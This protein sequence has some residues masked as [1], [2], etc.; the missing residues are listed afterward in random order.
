MIYFLY[1]K[2]YPFLN[3]RFKFQYA[4]IDA[5]DDGFPFAG[6]DF[7]KKAYAKAI[8]EKYKFYAFEDALLII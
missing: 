3:F 7:I 6:H 2:R 8:N 5:D 1:P 4:K